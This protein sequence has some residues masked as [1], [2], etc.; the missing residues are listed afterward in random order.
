MN[1]ITIRIAHEEEPFAGSFVIEQAG[2]YH[3]GLTWDEMLGQ[4]VS[5]T[6][7]STADR[8]KRWGGP[9]GSLYPMKTVEEWCA[10]EEERKERR[11]R[12]HSLAGTEATMAADTEVETP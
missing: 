7:A 6:F 2:R 11:V 9:S 3:H 5:L 10:E 1:P 8:I 4:V 12:G